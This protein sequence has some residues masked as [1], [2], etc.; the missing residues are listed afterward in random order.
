MRNG[1]LRVT[2]V[3]RGGGVKSIVARSHFKPT[4]HRTGW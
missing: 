2:Y 1:D 4:D 3:P